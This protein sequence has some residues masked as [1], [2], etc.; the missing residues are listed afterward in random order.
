MKFTGRFTGAT[1]DTRAWRAQ[2]RNHLEAKLN[3]GAKAWLGG[4]TGRV[5][6]W[7]GMSQASLLKLSELVGGTIIISPK[8]GVKSRIPQGRDL[9]SATLVITDT[10]FTITIVTEVP[11]Y[12]Y[13]E[14][15]KGVSRTSPW[16][17]QFA[18]NEAFRAVVQDV[19]IPPLIFKPVVKTL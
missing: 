6:V 17:S 1:L 16:F 7:S 15:K 12:T 9:G 14:Y 3:E 8:Q 19:T 10:D 2:L 13:Q 4:V 18:G 5:P 11:H